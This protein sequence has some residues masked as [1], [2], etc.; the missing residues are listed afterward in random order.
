MNADPSRDLGEQDRPS[1][2][3][4]ITDDNEVNIVLRCETPEMAEAYQR[5]LLTRRAMP[6]IHQ[7]FGVWADSGRD[8]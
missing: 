1:V 3:A 7:Q 2:T 6:V 4:A 5:W 8:D